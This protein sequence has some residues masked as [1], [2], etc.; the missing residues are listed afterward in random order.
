MP[1]VLPTAFQQ[2]SIDYLAVLPMIIVVA[3]ALVGV[4]VEAFAPR[5]RRHPIQVWLTVGTLLVALVVL[6]VWSRDHQA[7]TLGGSVAVDGVSLFLQGTLLLLSVIGVLVMAERFGGVGSD[8]FTPMGASTPG[9][10]QEDAATRA[11]YA[12]SEVFP[13][14]LFAVLGMMVFVSANDLITLFVGLEVLS[15]PLYVMTGLARRRR[16]LSQEA[17]LKYFLL[18]AFSSAFFLFGAALL[19]GYAGS[20]DLKVL[21]SAIQTNAGDLDG[22]LLPG[23]VLTLVGLLFK[24]GAVP[25]HSWTPDAYQGAPTPVTGFMA[26]CTKLAAFGA[27]LRLTYVGVAPDRWDWQIGV[28][29]IAILTMVVGAVLSVTQTDVKR[30]LAYSSIAHAGFIL[31]GV[32]A[33]SRTAIGGVMFYLLAYGATTIAA[34]AIVTMV[35]QDG[36]EASHLSQ[37]AGLGRNHPVVAGTFAFLLLAFAGIPLT[38]GFTAKFAAFAPAVQSGTAGTVM[39]VVGVLASAVTAFVYVRL[40]VLMYFTEPV[41][42]VVALQPSVPST[43]AITLGVAVT[44]VAGVAPAVVLELANNASQFLL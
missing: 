28:V 8:A 31:V 35:R 26:A 6:A 44:V 36:S 16:L 39:V 30:L 18:G 38:S 34:F 40:I 3:G 10:T 32:L 37:W 4:L 7:V 24:V 9:S 5:D 23:V 13:L 14:T 2:A 17:A 22:L 20:A 43:I 42:G 21:A 19:F 12:T 27:I 25:F 33:F 11:G 29:V 41:E 1:A 15:L